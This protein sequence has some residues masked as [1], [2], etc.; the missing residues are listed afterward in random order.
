MEN[1]IRPIAVYTT[2]GD[3]GGF[4]VYPYLFNTQGEWI[5][6]VTQQREVYSVLGIFVGR[7]SNDP[8]ILRIR[9]EDYTHPRKMPPFVPDRIYPPATVPLAPLMPELSFDTMDVLFEEP[10]LLH[11]IDAGDMREDMD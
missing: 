4:L 1:P 7:L 5:G 3:A 10:D 11:T 9:V 2:R 6:W 8:R